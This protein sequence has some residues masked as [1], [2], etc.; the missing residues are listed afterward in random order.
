MGLFSFNEMQE[1]HSKAVS[2]GL[3]TQRAAL[4]SWFPPDV[5][6]NLPGWNAPN[7]GGALA[8]DLNQ[9]NQW[10]EPIDGSVLFSR[11][12]RQ[13]SALLGPA[14]P[15]MAAFFDERAQLAV[16]RSV[17]KSPATA[18][19]ISTAAPVAK[20]DV[21]VPERI[22]TG[23]LLP[24]AFIDQ[25]AA[26]MKAVARL[27]VPQLEG[28]APRLFPSG[29]PKAVYGTGWMIGP[30]HLITNSHVICAR[31]EGEA[32]PDG[33]DIAAQAAAMTV[34]FDYVTEGIPGDKAAVIDL[35]RRNE[36]LDYA[37]VELTS[38]PVGRS[39]FPLASNAVILDKEHPFATNI[40]Q[41]PAGA[42]RQIAIRNNLAAALTGNDLAYFTDTAGGSSGSPVCDD[43]WRV[44]AL[45]KAATVNL[46]SF[47]IN[48]K[49]TIWINVG[50]QITAICDDLQANA[51]ALWADI[52]ATLS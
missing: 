4:L 8:L 20:D 46:G 44:I 19:A 27:T 41:H 7:L 29:V 42:P 32:A 15:S 48:G 12:L 38:A 18:A 33:Q 23:T 34:E 43:Q 30:K 52:H 13:A 24:S 26:R 37:I 35:V 36:A 11:W 16:E 5:Q 40:I 3:A 1:I 31:A 25:A 9:L 17:Q 22:I 51:P 49:E 21:V 2:G 28:G 47:D 45:H 50:T 10:T 39:P 6:A 14:S